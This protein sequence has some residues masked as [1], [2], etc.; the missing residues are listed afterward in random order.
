MSFLWCESKF[1]K[2]WIRNSCFTHKGGR[3]TGA[4]GSVQAG[5][6]FWNYLCWCWPATLH[7]RGTSA[8]FVLQAFMFHSHWGTH[9]TA[10][11]RILTARRWLTLAFHKVDW[12]HG[13]CSYVSIASPGCL[14]DGGYSRQERTQSCQGCTM[15]AKLRTKLIPQAERFTH[16]HSKDLK[17]SWRVKLEAQTRKK[18]KT[19]S[20]WKYVV[21]RLCGKSVNHHEGGGHPAFCYMKAN[22]ESWYLLP[23]KLWL[24]QGQG[25]GWEMWVELSS[26]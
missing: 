24:P 5:T 4:A 3:W 15:E 19:W 1:L 11:R 8:R 22:F 13:P 9:I 10:S 7:P 17:V 2:S 26:T 14:L 20:R 23:L 16:R 12:L 18:S 6:G 21:P 25:N